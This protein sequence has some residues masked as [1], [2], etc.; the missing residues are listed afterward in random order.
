[1]MESLSQNEEQNNRSWSKY[2][3]GSCMIDASVIPVV[4]GMLE[5]EAFNNMGDRLL[6]ESI[7]NVYEKL[8]SATP[9]IVSDDLKT[10][11][12]S[13]RVGDDKY[14]HDLALAVTETESVEYFCNRIRDSWTKRKFLGIGKAFSERAKETD[15]V[16]ELLDSCQQE[17]FRLS[18][19][20][21]PDNNVLISDDMSEIL[22]SVVNPEE[23]SGVRTGIVGLDT[24]AGGFSKGDMVI[25]AARPSMGKSAL[26]VNIMHNICINEGSPTLLFSLEMPR[27]HIITRLLSTESNIPYKA[28]ATGDVRNYERLASASSRLKQLQFAIVDRP[29]MKISTIRSEARRLKHRLP[30][31]SCIGI[32]YVQLIQ[33]AKE[34]GVREQ[35][36]ADVA[37]NLKALAIELEVP[38]IVAAQINRSHEQGTDRRPQ[39]SSLRESG[40]LEQTADMVGFLYRDDYYDDEVEN[41]GQTELII[42]KNR[43][44]PTGT[45]YMQFEKSI[46]TFKDY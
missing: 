3:L 46:M 32:D 17:L 42:R 25:L 28:L 36:V 27:K 21:V 11:K 15:D 38:I 40:E 1:M 35:E 22:K 16:K 45:V 24:L 20:T 8:Q 18:T 9:V 37:R 39:M 31:L 41:E 2:I 44:G 34:Y 4:T 5:P 19:D 23:F 6:F 26:L 10:R 29:G 13:N 7:I 43:N 33:S 12:M 30:D 14:L